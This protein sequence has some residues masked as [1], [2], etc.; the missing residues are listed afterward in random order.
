MK[1]Y[2]C[3]N[4]LKETDKFCGICGV[5]NPAFNETG[6]DGREREST[7]EFIEEI[8]PQ[9]EE[10]EKKTA[11][12]WLCIL[13]IIIIFILSVACGVLAQLH[14]GNTAAIITDFLGV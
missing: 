8:F 3:Q 10:K 11:P 12:L 7:P 9:K 4:E 14:F 5:P 1:C 2:N 13:C 6:T